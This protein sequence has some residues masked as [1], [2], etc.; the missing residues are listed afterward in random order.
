MRDEQTGT[1]WQQISGLAIAGPLAGHKLRL[2]SADELSFQ[3]WKSEQPHGEVLQDVPKYKRDYAPEDWDA[4]MAKVPVVI[5]FA[6][7]GLKNRDLMIGVSVAGASRA[8]P[9]D[10]V[11]YEKLVQDY[12][13]P[14][15]VIVVLAQDGRS[16]RVFDRRSAGL[17]ATPAF[18]RIGQG[19]AFLMDADTGSRW[20]F[21]GCA[22]EGR[23]KGTCL[24]Q[25]YAIKDYWFD[26]RNYHPDTTVYGVHSR[27]R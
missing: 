21:R 8:F 18:Y 11:V 19:E 14:V 24:K 10:T 26:W 13:G 9:Y 20:N 6:Q 22:V 23:L 25:V 16:V 12:I 27:I 3:L 15:P 4:E 1:Y 7:P 5:S 2:V 17:S